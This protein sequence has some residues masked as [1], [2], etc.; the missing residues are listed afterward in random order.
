MEPPRRATKLG[1]IILSFSSG[2]LTVNQSDSSNTFFW[3]FPAE[4]PVPKD[5]PVL[6][7]LQGGPGATSMF[8]IFDEHGPWTVTADL[9]LKPR[10][11]RWTL[12]ANVIYIDNP[13]GTGFSFTKTDDGYARTEDQVG[14]N[15]YE[16]LLQVLGN[17]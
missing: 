14:K 4:V 3:F 16:A 9:S 7:W 15:L 2:Y 6:V 12:L 13:V 10:E 1:I 5:A 17:R 8:G 11:Y